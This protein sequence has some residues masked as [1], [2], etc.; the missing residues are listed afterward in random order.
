MSNEIPVVFHNVSSY[1]YH[2]IIKELSNELEGQLECLG[3]N[4]EKYKTFS[5]TIKKEIIKIDKDGDK[6]VVIISYKIK[7]IDRVKFMVSSS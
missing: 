4:K 7:F 2:F 3:K 6:S 1:D 5:V